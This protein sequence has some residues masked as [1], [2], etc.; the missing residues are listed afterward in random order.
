[1]F[2][3]P[4]PHHARREVHS[5]R[6]RR[7]PCTCCTHSPNVL[8]MS[9][10]AL[11]LTRHRHAGVAADRGPHQARFARD[12]C[13]TALRFLD[14]AAGHSAITNSEACGPEH[15]PRR[16]KPSPPSTSRG[17]HTSGKLTDDPRLTR[18]G[19]LLRIWSLDETP[20][21]LNVLRGEMSLV[22]PRPP[23]TYEFN[24]YDVRARRRLD[25]SSRN[26]RP[27]PGEFAG[28][29]FISPAGGNGFAVHPASI[30]RA[31]PG[32]SSLR[33]IPAVLSR[34]GAA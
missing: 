24:L 26:H 21:L 30:A 20:Q 7:Q 9:P 19:R 5:H 6:R 1:M 27:P 13:S 12:Q 18:V 32:R 34:R 33:T 15:R 2:G 8:L 31:R 22:G 16:M 10:L 11:F 25:G 29:S 14:A 4:N 28:A 3:R 17:T 23:L